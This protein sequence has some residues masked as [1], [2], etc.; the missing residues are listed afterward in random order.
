MASRVEVGESTMTCK[1][2]LEDPCP[3]VKSAKKLIGTWARERRRQMG[4]DA[5]AFGRPLPDQ[6]AL[7]DKLPDEIF[8]VECDCPCHGQQ[9]EDSSLT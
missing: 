6:Q 4:E 5:A 1:K 8:K 3:V 9:Q 7:A 2:C